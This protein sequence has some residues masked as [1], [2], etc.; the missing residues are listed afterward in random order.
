M[1][2]PLELEGHWEVALVEMQY[3]MTWNMMSINDNVMGCLFEHSDDKGFLKPYPKK[4]KFVLA[5]NS[6]AQ[7]WSIFVKTTDIGRRNDF[8]KEDLKR[9]FPNYTRD[10]LVDK[11]QDGECDIDYAEFALSEGYTLQLF[12]MKGLFKSVDYFETK[13]NSGY[14][15]SAMHLAKSFAKDIQIQLHGVN[16]ALY[17]DAYSDLIEKGEYTGVGVKF[18]GDAEKIKLNVKIPKCTTSL[19]RYKSSEELHRVLG[20]IPVGEEPIVKEFLE[21]SKHSTRPQMKFKT[22]ALYVYSDIVEYQVVGDVKVPL[23][24]TVPID[25]QMGDFVHK[26][27]I[28]PYYKPITQGYINSILIEI[29]DDTGQDLEFKTGKVICTLYFRR[30][31][32]AV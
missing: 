14:Y 1:P 6:Y 30:C 8:T 13:N 22:P 10:V 18:D 12:Y 15:T 25:G 32:L 27:F 2:T 26:E 23:L 3:P 4:A 9:G 28:R 19:V 29:K 17:T 16:S 21:F 20:M 5:L 31:G 11:I 7:A 24:R